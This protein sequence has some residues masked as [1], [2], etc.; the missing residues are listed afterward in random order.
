MSGL[1]PL[2]GEA[3]RLVVKFQQG[4]TSLIQR[5]LSIGY[6]QASALMDQLESAGIVGPYT[7]PGRREVY[8]ESPNALEDHLEEMNLE[9]GRSEEIEPDDDEE[10]ENQTHKISIEIIDGRLDLRLNGLNELP[11]NIGD[12]VDLTE[13]NCQANYLTDLPES[14]GNLK[15]LTH[16]YLGHNELSNIPDSIGNLRKLKVLDLANNKITT[17]PDSLNKLERDI[18]LNLSGNPITRLPGFFQEFLNLQGIDLSQVSLIGDYTSHTTGEDPLETLIN[19]LNE[20]QY[21]LAEDAGKAALSYFNYIRNQ[22]EK[23]PVKKEIILS[24]VE[25]CISI[26][27]NRIS[28]TKYNSDQ[29]KRTIEKADL[30]NVFI[31]LYEQ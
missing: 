28:K 13:L 12:F 18:Y 9:P 23:E 16:L 11:A 20:Q 2:F 15:N 3:A 27:T 7:P 5:K 19:L 31:E 24:L 17:L 22:Q 26:Q 6:I 4:S 1:D 25:K 29:D 14:I 10:P 8:F 30:D 21:I